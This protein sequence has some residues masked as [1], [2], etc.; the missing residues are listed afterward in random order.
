MF[1]VY[2]FFQEVA[3][4]IL[5]NTVYSMV[6]NIA[7][8][9]DATIQGLHQELDNVQRRI[10]PTE[11]MVQNLRYALA[12]TKALEQFHTDGKDLNK[13]LPVYFSILLLYL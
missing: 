11:V 8:C 5:Q 2:L 1:H 4:R 13:C 3:L 9:K 12:N 10:G 6:S 7:S